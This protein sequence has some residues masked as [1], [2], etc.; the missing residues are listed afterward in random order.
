MSIAIHTLEVLSEHAGDDDALGEAIRAGRRS[1]A[2]AAPDD[3][4]R[5]ALLISLGNALYE[6]FKRTGDITVLYEAAEAI[7]R[8]AAS[9]TSTHPNYP[10]SLNNLSSVLQTLYERSGDP[11][12]LAE[13]VRASRDA[14]AAASPD[15]PH[16]GALLTNLGNALKVEALVTG[17]AATLTEA[18]QACRDAIAITPAGKP[19]HAGYLH[20]LAGVLRV[21]YERDGDAGALAEAEQVIRAAADVAPAGHPEHARTLATLGVILFRTFEH[22]GDTATL[23]QA[24]QAGRGAVAAVPA[25]RADHADYLN[26]LAMTLRSLFHRTGDR[27]ALAEAV[28]AGRAAVAETPQEHS[29]VGTY[30]NN[31]AISLLALAEAT[32][33]VATL[34]EA[35]QVSREAAAAASASDPHRPGRL[36][37]LS[38]VERELSERTKDPAL[39]AR[40]AQTARDAVKEA[41]PDHPDRAA[42]LAELGKTLRELS[43]QTGDATLLVEARERFM[44]AGRSTGAP[45]RV[46]FDS[47]LAAA[48]LPE[49]VTGT[50][51]DELD[52]I[53]SAIALIPQIT[54]RSLRRSDRERS[55]TRFTT[56]AEDAA[57][58]ALAAGRPDRAVELLEQTRGVLIADVL[59]A[60]S[61]DL[62]RLQDEQPA[63]AAEL[64]RLRARLEALDRPGEPADG[65][66]D[67]LAGWQ[68][69]VWARR[70]AYS[71][72]DQLLARI[73]TLH[74]FESFYAPLD[75][76]QLASMAGPSPVIFVYAGPSRSDALIL[77]D[78]EA[79]PVQVVPLVDLAQDEALVQVI[80]LHEAQWVTR[81]IAADRHV[82]AA[83]Q[84]EILDVLSWAWDT[85]TGPV[86]SALGYNETPEQSQPWPRVWWCPVGTLAYLPLHAAG[87]HGHG[88]TWE[89]HGDPRPR[90]VLDLV[91]S[92]YAATVRGLAHARTQPLPRETGDPLII[93]VPEPS[94]AVALPG[95]AAEAEELSRLLPGARILASPTRDAVLTELPCHPVVHFA[96]HGYADWA[97]PSDS[98]LILADGAAEP[99]TV[100]DISALRLEGELAYLSA[101]DSAVTSFMHI[102]EGTHITGA[103]QLAGYRHVIGTLWP[104]DDAKARDL[105]CEFYDYLTNGNSDLPNAGQ[106]PYALHHATR[107]L[108]D[109][110]PDAPTLW[111]GYTHTGA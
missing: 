23:L 78:N 83:A 15:D 20:N 54:P 62:A 111:A 5:S 34:M 96:C 6:V 17:E 36:S 73:R 66:G 19:E 67:Y 26:A 31:L 40:A 37:N 50:P 64:D 75:A 4:D 47:Y 43:G 80:R 21:R 22:T 72:W 51:E 82:R 25:G 87:H 100:A 65:R 95:A 12:A 106:A 99:L 94:D 109:Q 56:L 42:F 79:S 46:R 102:N 71:D 16:R 90:T 85:I 63:L 28:R 101:C 32:G 30:L 77:K 27:E 33:D 52:V 13:A 10:R 1:L 93:A 38:R 59:D 76:G 108:R 18:V 53:E 49:A 24:A 74:G 105:A 58:K 107:K 29:Y 55:L 70:N 9:V 11:D 98:K 89:G 69:T 103:F 60:R 41:S 97:N 48:G 88:A 2:A 8:A 44:E 61:S 45:A 92:S 84:A 91:V 35:A 86:L 104:I 7:R 68:E 3:P 39:L 110:L 57:A 14:L 81:D